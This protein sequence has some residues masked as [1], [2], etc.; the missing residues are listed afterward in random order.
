MPHTQPH[1]RTGPVSDDE[2]AA[3]IG[4]VEQLRH[5]IFRREQALAADIDML[6]RRANRMLGRCTD[7]AQEGRVRSAQA[8]L[9]CVQCGLVVAA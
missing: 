9:H 6:P 8:L 1:P 4:S 7:T 2:I 3:L 5:R